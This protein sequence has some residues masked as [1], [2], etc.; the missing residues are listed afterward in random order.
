MREALGQKAPGAQQIGSLA[1]ELAVG[2]E[3]RR[4]RG[5]IVDGGGADRN[6][7]GALVRGRKTPA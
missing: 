2:V 5:K 7:H 3:Q 6:G 1:V 4:E